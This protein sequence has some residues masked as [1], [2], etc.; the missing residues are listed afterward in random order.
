MNRPV[1]SNPL[2]EYLCA[3]V[4]IVHVALVAW[5]S[6]IHSP[7][8]DE[9][10][11]LSSGLTILAKGNF[12][13]YSVN[14]PLVKTI[15]ALPLLP[16]RL[17]VPTVETDSPR[18]EFSVGIEFLKENRDSFRRYFFWARLACLPFSLLGAAV[19]FL[20]ARDLFGKMSG[21]AALSLWCL[22][23]NMIG[24]SSTI[25]PDTAAASLGLS[26]CYIFSKWLKNGTL[27]RTLLLGI[28]LGFSELAKMSWII[29]IVILPAVWLV[30]QW[31]NIGRDRRTV[32][33]SGVRLLVSFLAALLIL[34]SFYLFDGTMTKIG[35]ISFRS[36][37]FRYVQKA[38]I[39]GVRAA[40][41]P[42]PLPVDY[43][44][45]MDIQK[46]DFESGRFDSYLLGKWQQG[47]GWYSYYLVGLLVKVPTAVLILFVMSAAFCFILRSRFIHKSDLAVLLLPPLFFFVFIS[48][49]NGFSRHFRYVLPVL[50][51]LYI[52]ASGCFSKSIEQQKIY[53][54]STLLLLW[55]AFS[56]LMSYPNSLSYFNAVA[57]GTKNGYRVL[58]DSAVDWGQDFYLLKDWQAK[59]TDARPFY[60]DCYSEIPPEIFGIEND[61]PPAGSRNPTECGLSPFPP[62]GWYAIS[63]HELMHHSNNY[64]F[65]QRQRP[66]A[67]IGGS[68][69]I[70]RIEEKKRVP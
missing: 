48:S 55:T 70:Y 33:K 19:C 29:F 43:V 21:L 56:S 61:G 26:T 35:D 1:K 17:T 24:L 4:L 11:H 54:F 52:L 25:C 18:P 34:N 5:S 49:Q 27:K 15:A 37:F 59:H 68:I 32:L 13:L 53:R 47:K 20:W 64:F 3:S 28:A 14:P 12:E 16:L 40:K 50:P 45:G 23:P 65:F 44:K 60:I 22:S 58:L 7:N 63:I 6:W 69:N 38:E 36:Q 57:G 31:K 51:F 39:C 30:F 66:Y 2:C 8:I 42:V 9:A 46:V 10:A 67:K 62:A 41:I